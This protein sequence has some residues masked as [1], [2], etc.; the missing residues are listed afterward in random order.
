ML[1][2]VLHGPGTSEFQLLQQ[3]N[4]I[5]FQNSVE[6]KTLIVLGRGAEAVKKYGEF[7][8]H[9]QHKPKKLHICTQPV[10][11]STIAISAQSL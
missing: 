7:F 11:I 6:A 5:T 3:Q 4:V 9:K 1:L 8:L 2:S 10:I